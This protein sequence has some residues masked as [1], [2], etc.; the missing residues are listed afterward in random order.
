MYWGVILGPNKAI[1][2]RN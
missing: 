2:S 1:Y